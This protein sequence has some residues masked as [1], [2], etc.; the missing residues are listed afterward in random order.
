MIGAVPNLILAS[1]SPRRRELLAHL[2]LQFAVHVADVDETPQAGE[3][4]VGL[5]LRL[6]QRK[7]LAVSRVVA[8]GSVIV[9]A[10]TVVS[11]E[12]LLLGKPVD[13]DDSRRMLKRLS[14]RNHQVTTGVAVA[15]GACIE[16]LAVVTQVWMRPISDDEMEQY[17]TGG[18]PHDKAGSYAIQGIGGRFVERIEGSYSNVVGLPLVETERLLMQVWAT[19]Q[20]AGS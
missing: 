6:A 2:G 19:T 18:E 13:R 9:A 14:G 3:T 8:D 10:D 20:S 1:A 11:V 16:S 15:C 17:W 4:A 7:A 12:D 5:A